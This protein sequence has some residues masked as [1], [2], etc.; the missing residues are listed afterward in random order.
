MTAGEESRLARLSELCLGLPGAKREAMGEHTA[1]LVRGKKFA[2]FLD[3][4]HG[5][6]RIAVL[7]RLFPEEQ[8]A[9]LDLGEE[10]FFMPDY[11]GPRGWIGIRLDHEPVDWDEITDFVMES[12][13]TV[14]AE[15]KA[16]R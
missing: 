12:Y 9:L 3:N 7:C 1:F 11:L 5:D 14:L 8:Q 15:S 16:R 2:Y 4:H 6:G 10:R 13:E